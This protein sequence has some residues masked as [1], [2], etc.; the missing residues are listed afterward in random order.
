M[1]ADH[2]RK[3][4]PTLAARYQRLMTD[5]AR[6]H[7]AALCTIAA[8]LLTRI[9]ACLRSGQPYQLRDLDGRPI[10]PSQGR[11]IVAQRY[12]I[13]PEIRAARRSLTS[14][15]RPPRRDE[16]AKQ[17]VAKRSTATPAP[18]RA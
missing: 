4:D 1:A 5:T 2:A 13:P 15:Q 14:T 16:R 10:T 12:R 3:V 8:V 6:H 9:V 11:A 7:T 17:G 18:T